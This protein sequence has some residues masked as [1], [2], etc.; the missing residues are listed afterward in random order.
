MVANELEVVSSKID[1]FGWAQMSDALKDR[2]L[3]DWMAALQDYALHEVQAAIK[4]IQA[5]KPKDATN[6]ELVSK[7][8]VANRGREMKRLPKVGENEGYCSAI[9]TPEQ[10]AKADEIVKALGFNLKVK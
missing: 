7:R 4:Q 1:R 6:E 2:I 8:I 5:D 10:K 3:M 9:R